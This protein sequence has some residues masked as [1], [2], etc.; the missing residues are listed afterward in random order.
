MMVKNE[1]KNLPRLLDSV[2][3]L[4]L[5][6]EII[7][8][9]T[10]SE[11]KTIEVLQS[12]GAKVIIPDDIEEYYVDT[13][14]GKKIN[15]SKARNESIAHATGDWLL[16]LDADEEL[17][18]KADDLR[19]FLAAQTDDIEGIAIYFEDI[20]KG[21][22][23][24]R[25]PPPRIFRNGCIK[26]E[27]MVH[28]IPIFNDP[29]IIYPHLTVKH[30][31]FDLD[32]KKKQE[33]TERTLGLLEASLKENPSNF[34]V[35][36]YLAQMYGENADFTKCIEYCIKYIR[37]RPYLKRFNP[38]IYFTLVQACIYAKENVL[39]DKWLGEAMKELPDDIDIAM[40]IIDFGIWQQKPHV[41][42]QGSAMFVR[43]FDLLE[44]DKLSMGSRFIY[45]YN[46]DALVKALFHLS[47]MRLQE[48]INHLSRLKE[49]MKGIDRVKAKKVDEDLSRAL[50]AVNINWVHREEKKKRTPRKA[51]KK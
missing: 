19:D 30:Y 28:N 13:K 16:L 1:E 12:Y 14:F 42:L 26:Y 38:S 9:D 6:D 36:F 40:A 7:A 37:N 33:K 31:G 44:R 43:S 39:A 49:T 15:F 17:T 51:G 50:E 4:D 5:M 48:G 11:D 8:L 10:G 47:T 24:V 32:K 29:A 45:N 23:H 21:H 2:K 18:G 41:V 46:A 35:Y 22:I 3:K 34:R 20:Q 27:E 25:F